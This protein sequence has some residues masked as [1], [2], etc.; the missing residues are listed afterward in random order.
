LKV[1]ELI[2]DERGQNWPDVSAWYWHALLGWTHSPWWSVVVATNDAAPPIPGSRDLTPPVTNGE[3]RRATRSPFPPLNVS[4]VMPGVRALAAGRVDV[5]FA[6]TGAP[7][8]CAVNQP[9]GR[10]QPF[11][12][13]D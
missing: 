4:L 7:R 8:A 10:T 3:A 6:V 1:C 11:V 13:E 2:R 12:T 5:G 9:I